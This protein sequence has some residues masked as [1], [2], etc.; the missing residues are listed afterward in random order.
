[1]A[2][3][4]RSF[5]LAFMA[6]ALAACAHSDGGLSVAPPQAVGLDPGPF[7][8]LEAAVARGD[9]PKT[10]SVLIVR[11]G[12]L[13]LEHYF[14]E[15]SPELLNNTRSA[16][17]SVTALAIGRAIE[18]GE[19]TSVRAH[20]FS[21]LDDLRPFRNDTP[22]K[23]AIT[24][25]DMLT[26]S[27]ALDC[28]DDDDASPGNEDNMHPQ[29]NW[30]RWAVD[31]PTMKRY[32]RDA[33]RLGPWRYCT[34]NAF[35]LGQVL[36]RATIMQT[37]KYIEHTILE[38][39]G[40]S[41]WQWPYSPAGEPMTGGGLEL[42]SRDLAKIAWMLVDHGR[43]QGRQIVPPAWIDSAFTARRHAYP[44]QDYGYF[45]WERHYKSACGPIDGWY[46]AGN[47]G[48]AIVMLRQLN[49]AVVVTREN[50]NTHG[51]H[52]QT[53]DLIERYILPAFP[54]LR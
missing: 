29:P 2:I 8:G 44:G 3:M 42:R 50:Y 26:M 14:G 19:I 38:P 39:L 52:Q 28:N 45:F 15:G 36:A 27:S 40:I 22:D 34:T 18:D 49:A 23:E 32:S 20:A 31:L 30:S 21:Y 43:W 33:S 46:M 48:N 1:M 41:A 11:N 51:M 17:K 16:T 24:I 4:T 54:C 7:K 13:V 53:I 10:T 9:Y 25:E 35:L 47:G 6:A 37:D 5:I 12:R